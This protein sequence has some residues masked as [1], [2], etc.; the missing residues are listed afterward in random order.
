M[1]ALNE[2]CDNIHEIVIFKNAVARF[3][4]RGK[5]FCVLVA[6]NCVSDCIFCSVYVENIDR[7]NGIFGKD[8]SDI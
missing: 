3:N 8:I 7:N 6:F 5:S 2:A 4:N 1:F